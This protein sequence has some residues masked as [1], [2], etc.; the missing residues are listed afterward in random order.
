MYSNRENA[1]HN[2]HTHSLYVSVIIYDHA[3]ARPSAPDSFHAHPCLAHVAQAIAYNGTQ[4]GVPLD[5][6]N[7]NA[8]AGQLTQRLWDTITGIQVGRVEGPEGWSVVVPEK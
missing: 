4:Y 7:P 8:V 5:K 6:S 2:V 1:E 3:F